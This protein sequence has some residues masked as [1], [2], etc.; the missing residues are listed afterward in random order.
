MKRTITSAVG[1]VVLSLLLLAGVPAPPPSTT[2]LDA[3]TTEIVSI[4][5]DG[6]QGN[7]RSSMP[8]ISADGRY[9]AFESSA[10][11]LVSADTNGCADIFVH[12]RQANQTTRVSV[13]SSGEQGDARSYTPSISADGRYVAFG[14]E[15]SN[16]VGDDTNGCADV[17]V[18]DR[19]TGW[20]RRVSVSSDGTEAN[21]SSA[22][23]HERGLSISADGR[24]VAFDSYASNLVEGDSNSRQDV[25]VHDRTTGESTLV[26]VDSDGHQFWDGSWH[27]SISSCG[28]FVAF[29]SVW[30]TFI[31][32]TNW[33]HDVFV[34]NRWTGETDYV[35]IATDG[36]I[37]DS[38]SKVPSISANGRYVAFESNATN[39]V[40]HD[41]NGWPDIFVHDCWEEETMR[42]SVASDGTQADWDS[43]TPSISAN[44]RYVAFASHATNLVPN[45]TNY[46]YDV[47]VHDLLTGE[48]TRVS[49]A[50]NGEQ[51]AVGAAYAPAASS[52]GQ[53]IAFGSTF[54]NLVS[55]DANGC[56][57]VFVRVR[58][59]SPPPPPPAK[60]RVEVSPEEIVPDG[61]SGADIFVELLDGQGQGVEWERVSLQVQPSSRGDQLG[62]LIP[63]ECTTDYKGQCLVYYLAPTPSEVFQHGYG[64]EKVTIRV[65][66]ESGFEEEVEIWFIYL[67][68]SQALPAH[69]TRNQDWENPSVYAIF[70]RKIDAASV[71][72]QTFRVASSWHYRDGLPCQYD[73][74]APDHVFCGLDLSDPQEHPNADKGLIITAEFK[75]G[76]E[77]LLG[78]DGTFLRRDYAWKIYTTPV[79]SPRIVPVQVSEGADL[80][81]RLPTVVRVHAGLDE[82]TTELDWV[83]A[84]V[85]LL[86][87]VGGQVTR[88]AH[89]FYPGELSGP[90][91]ARMKGNSANFYSRFG[92]LP[93][94]RSSGSYSLTAEVEPHDQKSPPLLQ[95]RVYTAAAGVTVRDQRF[96]F[97]DPLEIRGFPMVPD[98]L[99]VGDTYP[100]KAGD[101][102][103]DLFDKPVGRKGYVEL[104]RLFPLRYRGLNYASN[105]VSPVSVA[106]LPMSHRQRYLD[107]I[108]RLNGYYGGGI[109]VT[110]VV[111]IVP[112]AWMREMN[113]QDL[114]YHGADYHTCI[115]AED[116][117]VAAIPHCLGHIYG[118]EDKLPGE[119]ALH[120][121]DVERDRC[122]NSDYAELGY[123]IP[124]M[125]LG[126]G[127]LPPGQEGRVW[128]DEQHYRDLIPLFTSPPA[129]AAAPSPDAMTMA[130]GGAVVQEEGLSERGVLDVVELPARNPTF[131]APGGTGDYSL[132]L[133]DSG[134]TLLASHPFTPTFFTPEPGIEYASF[135]F[136]FSAPSETR[137]VDLLH[138][139]TVLTT[140]IASANPPTVSVTQP[141]PG[142]Y[143]GPI[144]IAWEASDPDGNEDLHFRAYYS[145]DDGATWYTLVFVTAAPTHTLETSQ[146]ANCQQCRVKVVADDG[147]FSAEAESASFSVTNPPQVAGGWPADGAINAAPYTQVAAVFRDAMD[148]STIGPSTFT[149]TDDQGNPIAGSVTYDLDTQQALFT[150]SVALTYSA[151][152]TATLDGAI[153]DAL[154]Q[155]L[156]PDYVW[157]FRV[158]GWPFGVHLPLVIRP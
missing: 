48:T 7:A 133:R 81:A 135:L 113:G 140:V 125:W 62:T 70:D 45:D 77:G 30:Y 156:G 44:G 14:S 57:D 36:T 106:S 1:L 58:A 85:R 51:G 64:E 134:G 74:S 17:F 104:T 2:A 117:S 114:I 132:Q 55:G 37:G 54:D 75:G 24:D 91:S 40:P 92:E 29:D 126:I 66:S 97:W 27:P 34:H 6:T 108:V 110:A 121:Y 25:F 150:P 95:P 18:H 26:S 31:T 143:G 79:L 147:F 102:I 49:I 131:P 109:G 9:V 87:P 56:S 20:T 122:V 103:A 35:S 152:Y 130:V 155:A 141:T 59:P 78:A 94:A 21:A 100:W 90:L 96:A 83:E 129:T 65:T 151:A 38:W 124:L 67:A 5:S 148:G 15:A 71:S 142:S 107:S 16:L 139:S 13:S 86:D 23:P 98:K 120:G 145:P 73:T 157:T 127:D 42:V 115:V 99:Y 72:T 101:V 123:T 39:L 84:D 89:H 19:Q 93:F 12:D 28:S 153:Q 118:L 146:F 88:T 112:T 69:G 61:V 10:D 116:A 32:D 22:W 63:E 41:S 43:Q 68:I 154:G 82:M 136:T 76:P 111:L 33:T 3:E 128:I 47:F 50:G 8:A 158:E 119:G 149:L 80:V 52:D 4:A 46:S 138:N 60:F 11:N 53:H 144:E 105:R 137:Q